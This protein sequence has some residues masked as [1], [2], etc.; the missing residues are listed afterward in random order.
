MSSVATVEAVPVVARSGRDSLFVAI[1]RQGP[2]TAAGLVLMTLFVAGGVIGVILLAF[3][4]LHHF[5]LDQTLAEALEKPVSRGHL[6][7]TDPLGRDLLARSLAGLGVSF[8]IGLI[9][10][11]ISVVVGMVLGLLAGYFRGVADLI[12]SAGIDQVRL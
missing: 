12:I 2:L 1:L 8:T 11:L 6:L 5:Y 4:A 10:T 9:V 7:G 3:P